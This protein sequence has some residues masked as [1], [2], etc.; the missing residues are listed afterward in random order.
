[1][2]EFTFPKATLTTLFRKLE[3]RIGVEMMVAQ[4]RLAT[5]VMEKTV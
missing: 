2:I 3:K 4:T 5:E 1:M